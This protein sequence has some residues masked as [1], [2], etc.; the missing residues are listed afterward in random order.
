MSPY[1]IPERQPD[2]IFKS[3]EDDSYL[4]HMWVI[5]VTDEDNARFAYKTSSKNWTSSCSSTILKDGAA[6]FSH[7]NVTIEDHELWDE[8]DS[9][10]FKHHYGL[11]Y[12]M[13]MLEKEVFTDS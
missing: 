6:Y 4:I 8:D 10:K 11:Y 7:D 2:I 1:E 5:E 13:L 9:L 12:A 3:L